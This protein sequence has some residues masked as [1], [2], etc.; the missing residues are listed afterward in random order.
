MFVIKFAKL[1]NIQTNEENGRG[2]ELNAFI[3]SYSKKSK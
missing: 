3:I 1:G 2:S